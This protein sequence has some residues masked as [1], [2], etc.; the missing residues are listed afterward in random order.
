[1][2]SLA[3]KNHKL[4]P[5]YGVYIY[6]ETALDCD[7]PIKAIFDSLGK[8][9]TND[10]KIQRLEVDKKELKRGKPGTLKVDV[11]ELD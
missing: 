1:M 9:I 7:N 8:V 3:C 2:L 5:P 6:M 10:K 11:W 4:K